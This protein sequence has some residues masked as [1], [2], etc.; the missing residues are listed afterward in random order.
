MICPITN[1]DN[2]FPTHIRLDGHTQTTGFV[3]CEHV[4]SFDISKRGYRVVERVSAEMLEKI[5]NVIFLEI[6]TDEEA[7]YSTEPREPVRGKSC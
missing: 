5:L 4:H 1:T 6:K 3:L 2:K 7:G